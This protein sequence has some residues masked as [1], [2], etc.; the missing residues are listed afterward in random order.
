[1]VVAV[2][3]S[4]M[5]IGGWYFRRADTAPTTRSAPACAGLSMR[6]FSPVLSPGPTT[7]GVFPVSLRMADLKE[8]RTGGT[9]EEMIAPSICSGST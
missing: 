7:R 2:P 6:M 1:M 8:F 3:I 4:T 5:I 9:T